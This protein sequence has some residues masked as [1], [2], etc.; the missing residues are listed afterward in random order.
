MSVLKRND[1][2]DTDY[3]EAK[4]ISVGHHLVRFARLKGLNVSE[5][6]LFWEA[7]ETGPQP[8]DFPLGSVESRA[9]ARAMI[10]RDKETDLFG[11]V[12]LCG[13]PLADCQGRWCGGVC[14]LVTGKFF[15]VK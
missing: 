2:H 11:R 13:H 9:A 3:V 1:R 15:N 8:G 5:R 12:T 4:L 14:G 10:E 6:T 7:A